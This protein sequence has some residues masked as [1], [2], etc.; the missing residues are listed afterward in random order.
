MKWKS[1]VG[2]GSIEDRDVNAGKIGKCNLQN[3]GL[4]WTYFELGGVVGHQ[5]GMIKQILSGSCTFMNSRL[6]VWGAYTLD[7]EY[8]LK[9]LFLEPY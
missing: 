8:L 1:A 6:I 2:E 7:Y 3:L 9:A 4:I 5:F